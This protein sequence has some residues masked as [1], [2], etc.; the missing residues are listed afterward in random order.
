MLYDVF[1]FPNDSV[2]DNDFPSIK[3]KLLSDAFT[4]PIVWVNVNTGD[5]IYP[6]P[7]VVLSDI[8]KVI[9]GNVLLVI[10]YENVPSE[11]IVTFVRVVTLLDRIVLY[12]YNCEG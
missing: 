8:D 2:V 1:Q 6:L 5:S 7:Y 3:F 4:G 11:L 9:P 12:K 10:V